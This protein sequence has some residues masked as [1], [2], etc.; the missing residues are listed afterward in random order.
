MKI[1]RRETRTGL[2]INLYLKKSLWVKLNENTSWRGNT[3]GCICSKVGQAENEPVKLKSVWN[4]CK[5][6]FTEGP[7]L[8]NVCENSVKSYHVYNKHIYNK[9][10]Q[11]GNKLEV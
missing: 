6:F 5:F 10:G 1:H 11:S 9:D 4:L 3:E 7:Y 8:W 2:I